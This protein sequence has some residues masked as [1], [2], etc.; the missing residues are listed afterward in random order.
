MCGKILQF[1]SEAQVSTRVL[2]TFMYNVL[3]QCVGVAV[4][5][6]SANIHE[7]TGGGS[8][9]KGSTYESTGIVS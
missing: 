6:E 8:V 1:T 9:W 7:G 3:I 4:P 2:S 5:E